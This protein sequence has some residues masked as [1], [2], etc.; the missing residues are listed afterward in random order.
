[1]LQEAEEVVTPLVWQQ[2]ESELEG[3]PDREWVQ[4]LIRGIKGGFRLGHDQSKVVLE[5]KGKSMYDAPQHSDII[6]E[7]LVKEVQNR[8]VWRVE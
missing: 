3:H 8:R 1:M 5:K 6:R 2:W 7:Y 4:L